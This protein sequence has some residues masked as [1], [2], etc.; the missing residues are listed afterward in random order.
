VFVDVTAAYDTVW[1][2]GLT[3][4]MLQLLPDRH[5]VHMIMEMVGNRSFTLTILNGKRNRLR[6]LKIG[7]PQG[8]VLVPLFFNIYIFDLQTTVSR[9]YAYAD[10]LAIMHADGY[11]QAVECVL[12]K[13]MATAGKYLQAWK[14]KISTTK[15]ALAVFHLDNKESK[16]EVKVNLSNETPPFCSEPK[17]LAVAL[18]RSLTYRRYHESLRKEV[19]NMRRI[20]EAACWLRLWC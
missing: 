17:Y 18:D 16:R 9:K 19:D 14:L 12:T 8:S 7:V 13:D 6:R 2:R 1:H 4:K 5:M 10:D 11:W 20:P 15:M 3:Y